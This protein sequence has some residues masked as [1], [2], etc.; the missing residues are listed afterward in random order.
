MDVTIAPSSSQPAGKADSGVAR[1]GKTGRNDP[2]TGTLHAGLGPTASEVRELGQAACENAACEKPEPT[3]RL[4]GARVG[5][6]RIVSAIGAGG[7][8]CV[9]RAE[10]HE[11]VRR[12]VAVKVLADSPDGSIDV[13]MAERFRCEQQ[14]LAQLNHPNIARLLDA[15]TLP[16]DVCPARRPFLV[17]ELVDGQ[18]LDQFCDEHWLSWPERVELVARLAEIVDHAH[19][20]GIVH[21]DLKPSNVLASLVDGVVHLTLIDFGIVGRAVANPG[22][23]SRNSPSVSRHCEDERVGTPRYASPEQMVG[24]RE[25][26][27][28]TDVFSLGAIL[29]RLLTGQAPIDWA[30]ASPPEPAEFL[31][32]LCRL[33]PPSLL[34]TAQRYQVTGLPSDLEVCSAVAM[35]R[36]AA[37]RYESA[38]QL[39]ADLRAVIDGEPLVAAAP[40]AAPSATPS[41]VPD[42]LTGSRLRLAAVG[43]ALAV[44]VGTATFAAVAATAFMLAQ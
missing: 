19:R 14:T 22:E 13:T 20:R 25:V 30:D 15:G 33:P 37:D 21:R 1:S 8:G 34:T 26:D 10:Q 36:R 9:Y 6:Y 31:H 18:P 27:A 5:R 40:S 12:D 29:F 28:R 38:R 2:E 43:F 39:A 44:F 32:Q 41:A 17:M 35:A 11:P 23:Q 16:A 42:P 4:L 24:R 3:D 7:M